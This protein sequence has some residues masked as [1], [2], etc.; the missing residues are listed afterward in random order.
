MFNQFI[1]FIKTNTNNNDKNTEILVAIRTDMPLTS[2]HINRLTKTIEDI[3]NKCEPDNF[4]TNSIVQEACERVFGK[5]RIEWEVICPDI[6][7]KF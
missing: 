4:N 5:D 3:Q 1:K 7:I 6:E 2:G